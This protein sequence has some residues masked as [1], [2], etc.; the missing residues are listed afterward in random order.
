MAEQT[1]TVTVTVTV[2]C[3]AF[4]AVQEVAGELVPA[5]LLAERVGLLAALTQ[6]MTAA[7]VAARWNDGDLATLGSRVGPDGRALPAKGWMAL[8]RPGWAS[9][10]PE[11]VY[12][13]DRV[14]RV[15]EEAAAR[16]LR[17]AVHRR[18]VVHAI[19]GSWPADP[20]RRTDGEWAALRGRLPQ[21][22]DNAEIRN[23]T[24]QIRAYTTDHGGRLPACLAELEAAPRTGGMVLLAAADKQ[25]VT[26]QRTGPDTAVLRVKLPLIERPAAPARWA[27]TGASTRC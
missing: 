26:I 18:A 5:R 6:H 23:R 9:V 13:P 27:W 16:A 15:A 22:V 21:G 7:V 11:G 24:R 14:R 8:R 12:L 19:V 4:G 25:L 17:L 20:R 10:A 3:T 1:A 2:T